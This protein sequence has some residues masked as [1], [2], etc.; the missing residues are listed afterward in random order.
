MGDKA[1]VPSAPM[2]VVSGGGEASGAGTNPISTR[3][4]SLRG[5]S[6]RDKDRDR[7]EP[8]ALSPDIGGARGVGT[9][10]VTRIRVLEDAAARPDENDWSF[11]DDASLGGRAPRSCCTPRRLSA[12][13]A[14]ASSTPAVGLWALSP[15]RGRAESGSLRPVDSLALR[16]DVDRRDDCGLGR[17]RRVGELG[18]A[19]SRPSGRDSRRAEPL[20]GVST[21]PPMGSSR[22]GGSGPRP[23]PGARAAM[24]PRSSWRRGT[25][26]SSSAPA[27][28]T[29]PLG[30]RAESG[31]RRARPSAAAARRAIERP[32]C[33]LGS[34]RSRAESG[35]AWTWGPGVVCSFVFDSTRYLSRWTRASVYTR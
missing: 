5:L 22:A 24:L 16:L 19:R 33:C 9:T 29:A 28:P 8:S 3:G 7:D 35:L 1:R 32:C 20:R 23:A 14:I 15:R 12:T 17:K 26:A 13:L 25:G 10:C 21:T 31:A 11:G 6:P 34:L 4:V 2:P 18:R 27:N 30:V